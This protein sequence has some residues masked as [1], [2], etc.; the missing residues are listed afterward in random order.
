MK[1]EKLYPKIINFIKSKGFKELSLN[2]VINI[3]YIR[4]EKLQTNHSPNKRLKGHGYYNQFWED[5]VGQEATKINSWGGSIRHRLS[6]GKQSFHLY[7][8]T[9]TLLIFSD[10]WAYTK[11]HQGVPEHLL[12]STLKETSMRIE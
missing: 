11:P 7:K 1:S 4:D 5:K 2:P 12:Q 8:P 10:Q 3:K 9:L 6:P